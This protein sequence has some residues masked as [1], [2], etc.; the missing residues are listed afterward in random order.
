MTK[1]TSA[2]LL[3]FLMLFSIV[4]CGKAGGDKP[5]DV[6]VPETTDSPVTTQSE[7]A[8]FID[9]FV[10]PATTAETATCD[11]WGIPV[12]D[13][14]G[15]E[16]KF[17]NADQVFSMYTYIIP[18][19]DG[20][21]LNEAC[22][23]RDI[24]AWE[25]FDIK[26][27]EETKPYDQLASY[28]QTLIQTGEHV[29]DAMYIGCRDLTP[30]ISE[31]LFADLLTVSELKVD[32]IWWDQATI[33]RNIIDDRLFYATS[34]LNL[35][36]IE[37]TYAMFFNEDMMKGLGLDFPYQ[38]VM[39]GYWTQEKLNE[40]AKEAAN[41]NGDNSFEYE[42]ERKATYGEVAV[43][44]FER[45]RLY[46]FDTEYVTR[47][48][49]YGVYEFTAHTDE[50]FGDAWSKIIDYCGS[51]DGRVLYCDESEYLRI[52]ADGRAL[53]LSAPL[54][55]ARI[56]N[57]YEKPFG[58]LPQPK[59]AEDQQNYEATFDENALAFCIPST[60]PNLRRTGVIVDYLTYES[61]RSIIPKYYDICV[62]RKALTA[63]ESRRSLE[64][65][66]NVKGIEVSVPYGWASDLSDALCAQARTGN[67]EIAPTIETYQEACIEAI[68]KTYEVYPTQSKAGR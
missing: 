38:L 3:A 30:L 53:F 40:Y 22:V 2:F 50:L 56:L 58:I 41:L 59:Y 28:A 18:D 65:I 63:E 52:F 8:D 7:L 33:N 36:T 10:P 46:G 37:S 12:Y 66:R 19:V 20:D 15:Y 17:L 11:G 29:Y 48:N 39:D 23:L 61:Y 27:T 31:N 54:K 6:T 44:G 42:A 24:L 21:V 49:Y 67:L 55:E 13:F 1:K 51:G 4:S 14:D 9:S 5:E 32:K 43:P 60:N 68:K 26:M 35:M 16:F 25:K 64:I 45:Y 62:S 47:K 57:H 34:D